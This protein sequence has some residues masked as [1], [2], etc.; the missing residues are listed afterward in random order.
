MNQHRK[1]ASTKPRRKL[2]PEFRGKAKAVA[3]IRNSAYVRQLEKRLEDLESRRREGWIS[4]DGEWCDIV[5]AARYVNKSQQTLRNLRSKG[6]GPVSFGRGSGVKYRP[7]HLKRYNAE[8]Y[9][10]A[11]YDAEKQGRAPKTSD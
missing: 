1:I 9:T 11:D 10:Q 5:Y 7:E 6:I 8:G 4:Q 3:R 2:K